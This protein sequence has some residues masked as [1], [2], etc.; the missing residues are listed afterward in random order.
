VGAD[1][2]DA[3]AAVGGAALSKTVGSNS[4]IHWLEEK[5]EKMIEF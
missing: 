2:C 5:T 4:P 1:F 3:D